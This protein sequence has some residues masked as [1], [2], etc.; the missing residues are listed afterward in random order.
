MLFACLLSNAQTTVSFQISLST[1]D[2]WEKAKGVSH[3]FV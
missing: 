1:D 3:F 2:G